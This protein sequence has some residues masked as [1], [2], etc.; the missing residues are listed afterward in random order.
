MRAGQ[1]SGCYMAFCSS[2]IFALYP[3]CPGHPPGLGK[4]MESCPSSKDGTLIPVIEGL[5][6]GEAKGSGKHW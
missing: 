5:Q 2:R 4:E 6:T 3:W 1:E